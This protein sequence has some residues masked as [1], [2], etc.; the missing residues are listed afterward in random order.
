MSAKRLTTLDDP[1]PADGEPITIER[2]AKLPLS[3]WPAPPSKS[4][5]TR[6]TTRMAAIDPA[7]LAAARGDTAPTAPPPGEDPFGGLIP[8]YDD[9]DTLDDRW[10]SIAPARTAAQMVPRLLMEQHDLLELPRDPRHGFVL[11]QIDGRRTVAEIAD[12]CQLL[13]GEACDILAQLAAL[14][15]V[16]LT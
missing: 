9:E 12:A 8:V 6:A 3:A 7:L 1:C 11:C 15:A 10:D 16:E 2:R 13:D 5:T 14:G 4:F